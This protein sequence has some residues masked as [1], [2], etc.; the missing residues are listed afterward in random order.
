MVQISADVHG[1]NLRRAL[2]LVAA[3]GLLGV[4]MA[5]AAYPSGTIVCW[6]DNSLNQANVPATLTNAVTLAGGSY[7]ALALRDDGTVIAWGDDSYGQTNV[8][9]GLVAQAVAGGL[10]HSLAL[11]N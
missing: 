5:R 11:Q 6:G 2:A 7:H 10:Y 9:A 1:T 3:L 4:T 8:P